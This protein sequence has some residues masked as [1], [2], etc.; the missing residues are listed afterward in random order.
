MMHTRSL[1]YEEVETPALV[2][3]L[4]PFFYMNSNLGGLTLAKWIE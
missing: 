2:F 4:Q 1:L 3:P